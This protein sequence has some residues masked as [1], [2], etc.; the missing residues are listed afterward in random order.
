[1]KRWELRGDWRKPHVMYPS[2][3]FGGVIKSRRMRWVGHVACVGSQTHIHTHTHTQNTLV[4]NQKERNSL[5]KL[6][7][8]WWIILK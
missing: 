5:K 8:D 6:G 3:S 4:H 7:V 1:M 2:Q